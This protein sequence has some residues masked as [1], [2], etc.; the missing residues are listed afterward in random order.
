MSRLDH[1]LS[2]VFRSGDCSRCGSSLLGTENGGGHCGG[3]N[4]HEISFKRLRGVGTLP[5]FYLNGFG[6]NLVAVRDGGHVGPCNALTG[7]AIN[8]MNNN[9]D[10][11]NVRF[12]CSCG[13]HNR[14]NFEA[15]REAP[16]SV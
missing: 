11:A 14:R 15:V 9:N 1:K 16:K 2:L 6:N 12:S 3:V 8:F 7:E 13:L 5:V 4:G 10:N